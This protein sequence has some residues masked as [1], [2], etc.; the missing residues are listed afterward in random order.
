VDTGEQGS[1]V[2]RTTPAA[3]CG[4]PSTH[5]HPGW[6]LRTLPHAGPAPRDPAVS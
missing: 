3:N 5:V 2:R 6:G 4:T 1:P